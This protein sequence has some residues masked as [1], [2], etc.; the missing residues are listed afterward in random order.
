MTC[1]GFYAQLA[2][3]AVG[4]YLAALETGFSQDFTCAACKRCGRARLLPMPR[5]PFCGERTSTRVTIEQDV[6]L[7]SWT[8]TH[9]ELNPAWAA[10]LPFTVVTVDNAQGLRIHVPL[11]SDAGIGLLVA[12]APMYLHLETVAGGHLPV[13]H[14]REPAGS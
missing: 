14:P 3:D 1:A 12:D 2:D 8:T 13:A 10:A 4:P 6:R 7:Y 9:H 5:C 11:C